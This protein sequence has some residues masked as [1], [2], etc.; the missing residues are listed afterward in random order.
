MSHRNAKAFKK[1]D[2]VTGVAK[3][4]PKT[5]TTQ[6][7]R[8]ESVP[9][10]FPNDADNHRMWKE[11]AAIHFLKE[12]GDFGKFITTGRMFKPSVPMRPAFR[13]P[14]AAR[15]RALDDA[16]VDADQ[17]GV[18]DDESQAD[19]SDTASATKLKQMSTTSSILMR[20]ALKLFI[21]KTSRRTQSKSIERKSLGLE[22]T[23]TLLRTC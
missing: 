20:K 6:F 13:R 16:S 9:I 2:A 19:F 4:K 18:E 23:P 3:A 17:E 21:L 8:V 7:T 15:A 10:L 14:A 11:A 5:I 1:A 12:Y 22:C